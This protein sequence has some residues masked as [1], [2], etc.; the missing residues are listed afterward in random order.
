MRLRKIDITAATVF[1]MLSAASYALGFFLI[2]DHRNKPMVARIHLIIIIYGG[3]QSF[4]GFFTG[5]FLARCC[6]DDDRTYVQLEQL[7]TSIGVVD[8]L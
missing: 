2:L 3:V 6:S 4:I 8:A 5:Y 1:V 7:D